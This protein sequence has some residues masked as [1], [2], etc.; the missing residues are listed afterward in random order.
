MPF[1]IEIIC[2]GS[3]NYQRLEP[4]ASLLT[5]TQSEFQFALPPLRLREFGFSFDRSEFVTREVFDFLR[6]YRKQA[7]GYRPFLIAVVNGPL[8]S[9]KLSNLFGSHE[10]KDGVAVFTLRDQ[11]LF[12]NS[13]PAFICYYFIRYAL[14]FLAPGLKSHGDTRTCFFDKK[15]DKR[16]LLKSLQTGSFCDPCR[17]ALQRHFNP[18]IYRAIIAMV[19]IL[20]GSS[21]N[22]PLMKQVTSEDVRKVATRQMLASGSTT[23]LDIKN[24]L[25]HEGY[26]AEQ[27]TVSQIVKDLALK[28]GW[29]AKSEDNHLR[30]SMR[31]ATKRP[32]KRLRKPTA[33]RRPAQTPQAEIGIITALPKEYIAMKAALAGFEEESSIGNGA[34]RRY[35]IGEIK[36][37]HGGKHNIALGLATGMGNNN[38]AIRATLLLNHFPSVDVIIM[39]GIA[40]GVP[41]P[42]KAEDHVRLGDIVV[43]D[44]KGVI[45]YDMVKLKEIRSSPV[46]PSA[47]LIEG[48]KHLEADELT[49]KRPWDDAAQ[50]ILKKLKW[51]KPH[52]TKDLLYDSKK[53]TKKVKHP[54]DSQRVGTRPRVF[55]GPIASA[56]ELLKDPIKRDS[57]RDK[58][59][60]KAVEMEG[61]GIADATWTHDKG[62]LVIRGVCDYCDSHKNDDWQK[63]AA[64]VAAGYTK[65]LLES[66][67]P[68][69]AAPH[70]SAPIKAS[71]R[72]VGRKRT[73][74]RRIASLQLQ[75]PKISPTQIRRELRE[76]INWGKSIVDRV[77]ISIG[78]S[79]KEM[80]A[81]PPDQKV[82]HTEGDDWRDAVEK[83][84]KQ[85]K[86][87]ELPTR[88]DTIW[89]LHAEERTRQE[90]SEATRYTRTQQRIVDYLKE[91]ECQYE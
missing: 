63:Y 41:R 6:E 76:A 4:V 22:N 33:A 40:G 13:A 55:S 16:D 67:F 56:N 25:R 10:A 64:A 24:A 18:E 34:G 78:L 38:A 61:S 37:L 65:A 90:G 7:G 23:T 57:L 3:D 32:R 12:T 5:S 77:K 27:R 42:N 1:P 60:V 73:R 2:L 29:L 39:V 36:S 49:G 46:T 11:S 79:L 80:E 66:A 30:Y 21:T 68:H 70:H 15:L 45:Q 26:F 51:K 88:Y 87:D 44:K 19:D 54:R 74:I 48:V 20:K 47:W 50:K 9:D 69:K 52:Q 89:K 75:K 62:Y 85:I 35:G 53:T 17:A 71:Q 81:L 28:H 31:S 86:G 59:G 58:F 84:L 14:S 82:S 72:A 91:L 43:S 83:L 8:R